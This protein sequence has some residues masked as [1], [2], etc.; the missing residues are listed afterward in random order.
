MYIYMYKEG[1][2]RGGEMVRCKCPEPPMK[3]PE[4]KRCYACLGGVLTGSER[5]QTE[6]GGRASKK[7]GKKACICRSEEAK[8]AKQL[9]FSTPR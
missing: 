7:E 9:L 5:V 1:G 6:R 3:M 4:K 8:K 2:D